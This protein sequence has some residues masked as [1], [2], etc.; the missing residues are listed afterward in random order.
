MNPFAPIGRSTMTLLAHIGRLSMFTGTA[1]AA[2]VA[3]PI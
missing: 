1:L 2:I 3:P